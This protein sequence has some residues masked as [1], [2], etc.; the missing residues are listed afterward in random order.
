MPKPLHSHSKVQFGDGLLVIG[1]ISNWNSPQ[2]NTT[3]FIVYKVD[4]E[5]GRGEQFIQQS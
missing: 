2:Q 5:N 1:G 4:F 3:G